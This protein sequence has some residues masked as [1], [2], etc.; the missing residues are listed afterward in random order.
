MSSEPRVPTGLCGET[1]E[2]SS[3]GLNRF[4]GLVQDSSKEP[5]TPNDASFAAKTSSVVILP[6]TVELRKDQAVSVL[7]ARPIALETSRIGEPALKAV[8]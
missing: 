6:E 2:I 3:S 8:A 7:T 1:Q 5:M 4:I